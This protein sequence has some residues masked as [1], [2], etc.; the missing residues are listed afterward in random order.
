ML[1]RALTSPIEA[2]MGFRITFASSAGGELLLVFWMVVITS[3]YKSMALTNFE[4]MVG[5]ISPPR[6]FAESSN[7]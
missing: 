6:A 2:W 4:V 3:F 5:M 7:V 1:A